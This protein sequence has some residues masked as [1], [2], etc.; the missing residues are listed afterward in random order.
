MADKGKKGPRW[1]RPQEELLLELLCK[2]PPIGGEDDGQ[3]GRKQDVIWA[4]MLAAFEARLPA[5]NAVAIS[6]KGE[7]KTDFS[8]P[9]LPRKWRDWNV[10]Y[11][12]TKLKHDIVRHS[13]K[14]GAAVED[15]DCKTIEQKIKAATKDWWA[16]GTFHEFFG[17]MARNN[18]QLV[19][20]G[21]HQETPAIA[22]QEKKSAEK[23]ITVTPDSLGD[24]DSDA[25]IVTKK[26]PDNKRLRVSAK[27]AE[28]TAYVQEK[29]TKADIELVDVRMAALVERDAQKAKQTL[30]LYR[31]VM[32]EQEKTA[33]RLQAQ[34]TK[35]KRVDKFTDL[36]L[37]AGSSPA[38]AH[39]KAREAVTTPVK[40][41]LEPVE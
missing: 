7:I 28:L 21:L 37:N 22:V 14:T 6:K 19:D 10:L 1:S 32:H 41:Q 38:T 27:N 30:T 17:S 8:G 26:A 33:M 9:A 25:E 16:F 5:V 36:Y 18:L 34:A 29:K 35:E 2:F 40:M 13:P 3:M 24:S 4:P 12:K 31:D 23:I 11:K 39:R 15:D 20:E